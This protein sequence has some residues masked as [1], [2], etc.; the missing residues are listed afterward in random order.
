MSKV[1]DKLL[2]CIA[3][4][5]EKAFWDSLGLASRGGVYEPKISEEAKAF[6]TG[7]VSK[8]EALFSKLVK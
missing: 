5:A 7:H 6:K 8:V 1:T 2:H 4:T 3:A